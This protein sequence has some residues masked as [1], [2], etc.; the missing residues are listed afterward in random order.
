MLNYSMLTK[1]GEILDRKAPLPDYPRPALRRES[2]LCLNGEWDYA[3][4]KSDDLPED[5]DGALLVPFPIESTLSGV[6][7]PLYP[8][9]RLFLRR[10]FTLPEGFLRGRLLLHC[11]ACD[12]STDIFCNGRLAAHS[13]NGYLP[14][15]CD[16]TDLLV[17]GENILIF[18]VRDDLLPDYPAGKQKRARGGIW[19]TPVSGVWQTV[20]LES[21][22]ERYIERLAVAGD[23]ETGEVT[24]TLHGGV[25]PLRLAVSFEGREVFRG[26]FSASDGKLSFSLPKEEIRPWSPDS[27]AL[28]DLTVEAEDDRVQSYFAFRSFRTEDG[29]FLLNGKPIFPNG[30]LD[31]GYFS[32]GIYTP[33]SYSLYRD[34]IE[35]MKKI[36]FNT[37]RKHAKVEP[38]IF[39]YLC[40]K[41]GML[42]FQ[43]M[44]NLPL[45]RFVRH[46]VLPF[47][48]LRKHK[49]PLRVTN[50]QKK[51]FHDQA[52]A[53]ADLLSPH[54]SVVLYTIFN[55]GWGQYRNSRIYEDLRAAGCTAVLDAASG[56]FSSEKP[57]DLQSE[58]IYFR[59]I[60]IRKRGELPVLLS[61]FGGYSLSLDG[62]RFHTDETFGYRIY[63][64][65]GELEE[66]FLSLYENEVIPA[67]KDG[68]AGAI[69]TQ[70]SDVEDECNGIL[71]YDRAVTKIS[72]D[73]ARAVMEKLYSAFAASF[74]SP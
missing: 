3:I 6:C 4:R 32:D 60:R 43:D 46:S 49:P 26:E 61:E 14:I 27:P 28:Y 66:G 68:L 38:Q 48:G 17:P 39:Y 71:T 72:P 24:V 21:V 58:H 41:L 45:Y 44:V 12:Q 70:L 36:G 42:V 53:I 33:A 25:S 50:K 30:V 9:E 34:D 23:P 56:W 74:V 19:Y 69:Y 8:G 13:E 64:T 15:D 37:L 16:L 59:P 10:S 67:L 65:T 20:W 22:P 73:R 40:D 35:A 63:R 62:H 5:C 2:Y 51:I 31:Q 29:R 55:E 47:L 1:Y 11:G 18:R 7:R 54:P 57:T 52:L